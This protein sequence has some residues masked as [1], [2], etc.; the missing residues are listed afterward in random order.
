MTSLIRS[1]LVSAIG[2]FLVVVASA[3]PSAAQGVTTAGITGVVKD[4]Q[5]AVVPGATIVAVHEPSGTTYTGVSQGDGRYTVPG[6]RVGGPYKITAELQG[7][8][9]E[10]KANITLN[11]GVITDVE[12]DLKLAAVSETVQVLSLIHI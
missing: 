4:S 5:G 6:M 9:T 8:G 7:F 12:F 2:A 1:C 10:E 3:T 11:L